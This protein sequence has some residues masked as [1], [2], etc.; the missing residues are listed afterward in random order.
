[1]NSRTTLRPPPVRPGR[2]AELLLNLFLHE[3]LPEFFHELFHALHG[4]RLGS[5][6][7]EGLPEP[8][9]ACEDPADAVEIVGQGAAKE[10]DRTCQARG[11]GHGVRAA[12][13]RE[14]ARGGLVEHVL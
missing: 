4:D 8:P 13:L 14:D 5:A 2:T 6:G 9:C 10:P 12:A 1:M 3:G 11:E 7:S